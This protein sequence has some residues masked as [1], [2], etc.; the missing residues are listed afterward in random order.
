ME[1]IK[2][3]FA[4]L[5]NT[6]AQIF[7]RDLNRFFRNKQVLDKRIKV[8]Y[9]DEMV[10]FPLINDDVVIESFFNEFVKKLNIAIVKR[11]PIVKSDYQPKTI[12]EVLGEDLSKEMMDFIPKSYD[13]IGNIA[14]IEFNSLPSTYREVKEHLK[15]KISEALMEVNKSVKTVFEKQ[16][17]IKNI[18]RLRELKLLAGIDNTETIYKENHCIFKL[19]V[20]T[21]FFTPRLVFERNRIALGAINPSETIA[22]LFAGVGPF[23]IQIV[24][25]HH[26]LVYGFDANPES[27]RYLKEN[28]ILN[29]LQGE[30]FPYNI[31]VK[32]LINP[33]NTI[34]NVLKGKID[35]VI[36]NLP[37]RSLDYLDVAL[38]LLKTEGIIHIYQ[39]CEKPNSIEKAIFNLKSSL[40]EFNR[41]IKK[42]IS[43]KVVKAYSPKAELVVI[44]IIVSKP[45]L[46]DV[47]N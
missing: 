31:D 44:D 15:I 29:D 39:F 4:M 28:I 42:V 38:Y 19:D 18:Y 8:L 16:S 6:D 35:R 30:I 37:E 9:E 17:K 2:K 41:K 20:K 47:K 1:K 5:K 32:E 46:N 13:I 26:V 14:I 43:A 25:N 7:L 27:I 3:K 34:G 21:T 11:I 10:L 40:K 23:S 24:R 36:M 45:L 12:E 33:S 22:D